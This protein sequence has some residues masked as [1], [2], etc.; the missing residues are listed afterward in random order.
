V[1]VLVL[2]E[3]AWLSSSLSFLCPP[4]TKR[5]CCDHESLTYSSF[6]NATDTGTVSKLSKPNTFLKESS[7]DN[8]CSNDNL[9]SLIKAQ[10]QILAALQKRAL[11]CKNELIIASTRC[12]NQ[13]VVDATNSEVATCD[14]KGPRSQVVEAERRE[15]LTL[16]AQSEM[17]N[18]RNHTMNI[19]T[20]CCPHRRHR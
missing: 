1:L 4:Q 15:L 13:V 11:S 6:S 17:I 16:H 3:L 14:L 5:G 10:M 2:L 19:F 7:N 9:S 8:L 20:H 12:L 18:L